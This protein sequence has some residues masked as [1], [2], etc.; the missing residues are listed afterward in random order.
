MSLPHNFKNLNI[1]AKFSNK[2]VSS[3]VNITFLECF[4]NKIGFKTLLEKTV[5]FNK[6]HNAK[7]NA[8]TI[9]DFLIDSSILG[10]S[11]FY[12]MDDLRNDFVYQNIKGIPLPSET[13]CRTL[14]TTLPDTACQELRSFNMELLSLKAINEDPREI[15]IDFDDTVCTI[16]GSQEGSAVGYNPKYKG[17][18]F[19]KE[20]IGC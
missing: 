13:T 14:L 9:L 1:S 8:A 17:R 12:H 11:R 7:Y 20:K 6:Y 15:M 4:K 19:F 5:C 16:F 18:P 10:F 2:T 3:N